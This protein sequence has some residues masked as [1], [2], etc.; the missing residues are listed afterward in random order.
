MDRSLIYLAVVA[1]RVNND[2][3]NYDDNDNN[4]DDDDGD[5]DDLCKVT[6]RSELPI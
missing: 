4:D 5:D 3:D 1:C 6:T 2:N